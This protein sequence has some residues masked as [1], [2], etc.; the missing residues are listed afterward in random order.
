MKSKID[1][2]MFD[3]SYDYVGDLAETIS[4][5]W[6]ESLNK[7]DISLSSLISKLNND[8]LNLEKIILNTLD[9]SG[10][11]ERWAFIKLILGGLRVGVSSLIVKK[12]L[13]IYGNK[14]LSD[15][16]KIWHALK[17]PYAELFLWLDNKGSFP[18]IDKTNIFH[19]L[20]LAH[21]ID[22]QKELLNLKLYNFII[23]YKWDGIRV[24]VIIKNDN[25]K[26]FSRTGEDITS[27]F[28]DISVKEKDFLVLDGE[29]LAGNFFKVMT[30]NDLQKRINKKK[31]SKKLIEKYPV[32]IRLYDILYYNNE[33]LRDKKLSERRISL[34]KWYKASIKKSFDLSPL[35]EIKKLD[36]LIFLKKKISEKEHIEGFMIKKKDSLYISG[37]KKG[38]W[39][40]WKRNPKYID[41][42]LMYAQRGHGKRSSY[43]SDYT[44]GVWKKNQVVP[45]TKAYSGYT[46]K[47]LS[48]IDNFVRRNTVSK[49][50]PVREVKKELVI[51]IAFDSIN[52]SNRH[53]SGVALRFPRIHRIRW[54]KPVDEVLDISEIKKEFF[55]NYTT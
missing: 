31:P 3:L 15:I 27:S 26:I 53:K 20:M 45:I 14:S 22:E 35:I 18:K 16:T 11:D 10:S 32:F 50:G 48:K 8:K 51:E 21:S 28:P 29:L 36:D 17:P 13:A 54:D 46:E 52:S 44:L 7:H 47:E 33:D 23:E 40:K 24:Q 43:Y 49:Y 2:Y 38:F 34:T 6:S 39:Y 30:F 1:P 4:L 37:R 25:I 19:P 42:I 5:I 12:A 9:N 41:T 55:K